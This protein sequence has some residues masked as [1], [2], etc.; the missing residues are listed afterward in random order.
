MRKWIL[1]AGYILICCY[2]CAGF[3]DEAPR[4][5]L[6]EED[7]YDTPAN[8]YLNTVATLYNYVGGYEDSQGLQGTC[9]GVYDLNTLTTDE[10]LLPD[11]RRRLVRRRTL[12]RT[13]PTRLGSQ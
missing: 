12:A 7:A 10:A 8:I 6:P 4:D 3:L 5:Q 9:R 13:V 11:P 1:W 2:G